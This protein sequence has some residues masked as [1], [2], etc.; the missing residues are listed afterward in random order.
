MNDC[1]YSLSIYENFDENLHS[2]SLSLFS[3]NLQNDKSGYLLM[4]MKRNFSIWIAS[5]DAMDSISIGGVLKEIFKM[6]RGDIF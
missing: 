6:T 4:V 1:I 2:L 5:I 3:K